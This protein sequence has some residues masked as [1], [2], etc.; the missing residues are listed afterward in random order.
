MSQIRSHKARRS[1]V[2]R[3]VYKTPY[4]GEVYGFV[5]QKLG[6]LQQRVGELLEEFPENQKLL[7][8]K[9]TFQLFCDTQLL[10]VP[11]INALSVLETAVHLIYEWN[12]SA[13]M[14]LKFGEELLSIIKSQ[15]VHWRRVELMSWNTFFDDV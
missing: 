15:V 7:Q 12:G 9:Q 13:P 11:L 3:N 14:K 8:I 5:S 6:K 1:Q 10:K 4:P 2:C